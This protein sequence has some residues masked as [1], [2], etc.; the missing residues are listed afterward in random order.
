MYFFSKS[1]NL[2][3]FAIGDNFSSN[4][5]GTFPIQYVGVLGPPHFEIT[6]DL[7]DLEHSKGISEGP[8]EWRIARSMHIL[9]VSWPPL[10]CRDPRISG[11]EGFLNYAYELFGHLERCRTPDLA[12]SQK[13]VPNGHQAKCQENSRRTAGNQPKETP[14]KTAVLAV[15]A[16]LPAVFRPLFRHFARGPFS[17]RA[18]VCQLFSR[19]GVRLFS[20]LPER[21]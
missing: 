8:L 3:H 18:A 2:C 6:S 17:N 20:K 21:S 11:K 4:F 9:E 12:N 16:V 15:S 7:R 5:S 1:L 13:R 10:G 19:S 14:E